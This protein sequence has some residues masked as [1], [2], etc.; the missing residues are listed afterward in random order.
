MA[1]PRSRRMRALAVPLGLALTASLGFLPNAASAAPQV[2]APAAASVSGGPLLSY[3]VNTT[4]GRATVGRVEKAIA[5]AGGKGIVAHERIGV[6]V[7]HSA[8]PKFAS[9]VRTVPGVQSAG[10]T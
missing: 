6:I 8:N 2:S 9:T 1:H 10:A 7:V 5:Q 3:V 4:P